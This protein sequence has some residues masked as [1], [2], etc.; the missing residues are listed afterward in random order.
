MKDFEYTY[1]CGANVSIVISPKK[2]RKEELINEIKLDSAAV[3]Y[4]LS[5]STQP[6]YSHHTGK[7][8]AVVLG[9]SIIQGS[10]VLNYREADYLYSLIDPDRFGTIY[11]NNPAY[12]DRSNFYY[13]LDY[14]NLKPF[15]IYI[16]EGNLNKASSYSAY[17][18]NDCY[19]TSRGQNIYSDDQNILEEYSFIGRS[20]SY[21]KNIIIQNDFTFNN[22]STIDNSNNEPTNMSDKNITESTNVDNKKI[23]LMLKALIQEK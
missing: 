21:F 11:K 20:Y 22:D 3:S 16:I 10:L 12:N 7:F 4:T 2:L 23:N 13:Y 15:Y 19:I 1:I 8:D 18:L 5:N 14:N 6:I 17:I 9:R